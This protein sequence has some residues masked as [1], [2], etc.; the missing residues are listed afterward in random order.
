MVK[1]SNY[2]LIDKKE[3]I[4]TYE[5]Y[6][7]IKFK[8]IKM[9]NE[10]EY[11]LYKSLLLNNNKIYDIKKDNNILYIYYNINENID[12]II[13]RK[14]NKECV[15]KGR[16][17]P[18]NKKEIEELFKKENAMC[19]I[20]SKKLING[21]LED[22]DGTGFFLEINMKDI[23][24]KKCLITNNHV[25]N[26]NDIKLN[27]EI[28]LEYKNKIKKIKIKENRKVYTNEE[29]DYTCIEILDKDNIKEYFKIDENLINITI[30]KRK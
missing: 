10:N 16:N 6:M 9:K 13:N 22:I 23:L 15:I 17:E 3:E 2:K 30:S 5:G 20:K 11:F 7:E 12:E 28:I 1:I 18:I 8:K 21:N 27:K 24:F 14:E 26:E 29:L 25:L 4:E 19:K